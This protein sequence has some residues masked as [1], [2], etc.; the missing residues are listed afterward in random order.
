MTRKASTFRIDPPVQSALENLS[1]VLRRPMNQLVNE[2]LQDYLDRRS[3]AAE[4]S[5]ELTLASLRAYRKRDPHFK[6]AFASV[7]DV[8]ATL[9]REDPAEGK[10]VIGK[11]VGGKLIEAP[12][13]EGINPLRAELR[14]LLNAS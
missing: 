9:G 2:A 12:P 14:R 7:V 4:R 5:L 3:R 10:V 8:E 11:L 1:R 6:D 13:A